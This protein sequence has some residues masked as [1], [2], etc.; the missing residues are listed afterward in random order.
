MKIRKFSFIAALAAGV[1]A[2]S[3]AL[4]A[5][6]NAPKR[7]GQPER[8]AGKRGPGG[9]G[10]PA[11]GARLAEELKLSEEQKTKVQDAF[12]QQ[13]EKLEALRNAPPEE[14]REK[15]RALR[16]EMDK[17]MKEILTSE[18]YEKFQKLREERGPV[19]PGKEGRR[20]EGGKKRGDK[21]G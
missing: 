4:Q 10:G 19:G 7:E 9:P 6:D 1:I 14:R 18:Q 2:F 16:E 8:P 17:K 20:P 13:R 21:K 12:K 11:F 15:A 3:P 5:Q